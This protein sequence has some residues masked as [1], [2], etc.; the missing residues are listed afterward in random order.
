[1]WRFLRGISLTWWIIIAM[2][3]GIFIGWAD[4]TLERHRRRGQAA[5]ALDDLPADDQVDRGA[6]H[7]RQPG[8]RHRGSW[9]RPEAGR[10]ARLQVDRLL[11]ARHHARAGHRPHRRQPGPA[12]R[13]RGPAPRRPPTSGKQLA[14]SQATLAERPGA[15]RSRRASSTRP[16]TTRS[17]RSCSS[18]MLFAIA[19]A[20]VKR[21]ARR[22]SML[23]FCRGAG[24][25]DVQVHRHR[26]DVRADRHRRGDRGDGGRTAASGVLKNLAQLVLTLYGALIVFMLLVLRPGGAHRA[27]SDQ[28]VLALR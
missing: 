1:M 7:L 2:V 16:R 6:A 5:A 18:S 26:D 28:A 14:S 23:G 24:R 22:T 21:P 27:G 9:R 19:L 3:I 8:R 17:C 13:R 10:P 12:R 4:H 25:G 15:H 11:R 20:Q